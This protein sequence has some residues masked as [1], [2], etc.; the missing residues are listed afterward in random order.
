MRKNRLLTCGIVFIMCFIL[1]TTPCLA[2][3]TGFDTEIV[4]D[5][6]KSVLINSL[7]IDI[8]TEDP[9]TNGDFSCF[10][11]NSSGEYALGFENLILVYNADK[12]F[13][14]GL[15]FHTTGSYGIELNDSYLIIYLRR[16]DAAVSVDSKGNVIEVA[17]IKVTD[18][19]EKYWDNFVDAIERT[20][21]EYTYTARNKIFNPPIGRMG[22]YSMLIRTG[23]DG[24]EDIL[25]DTS[26]RFN[27]STIILVIGSVLVTLGVTVGLVIIIR[28]KKIK[29]K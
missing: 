20:E 8:I 1:C 3:E 11:V 2:M 17:D 6:S 27:T 9:L 29:I 23:S 7:D 18:E 19:N 4:S 22:Y 21:G 13:K 14:Y 15:S 26:S 28:Q 24:A 25:F 10:D 16:S 5:D 12:T